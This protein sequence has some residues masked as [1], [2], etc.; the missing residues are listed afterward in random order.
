M[1]D[2]NDDEFIKFEVK[3]IKDGITLVQFELRRELEPSDLKKILPPDSVKNK[4][5]TNTVIL[6]GRGPIWLYGFFVH[7]YHPVR[8]ISVFDPRLNGAVVVESH[9]ND[10]DVG[11]LI[12]IEG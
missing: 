3:E 11:S 8:A 2:L 9:V 5:S 10:V 6:A 7:Y 12:K 1:A 4:F